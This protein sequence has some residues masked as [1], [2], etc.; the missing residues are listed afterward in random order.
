[1][2][3]TDKAGLPFFQIHMFGGFNIT[4]ADVQ[5]ADETMRTKK[6]WM[7]I[8]YLIANKDADASIDKIISDIWGDE[9]SDDPLNV[10]KNLVYRSRNI[11]KKLDGNTEFI[12]YSQNTYRWNPAVHCEVDSDIFKRSLDLAEKTKIDEEKIEHYFKAFQLYRGDFLPHSSYADW[13]INK[14]TYYASL[15]LTAVERICKILMD[16]ERYESVIEVCE[17]ASTHF[18][19]EEKIHE[20]LL[21]AYISTGRYSRAI[22]H[23]NYITELFYKELGVCLSDEIKGLYKKIINS[24]SSVE[25]DLSTICEDLQETSDIKGAFFC[26]YEV[27]KNIYRIQARSIARTGQSINIA[28]MTLMGKNKEI[29][30]E[31]V[32]KKSVNDLKITILNDLRK[33]DV[34]S[35]FSSV[36]FV[37][38]LPVTTCEMANMVCQRIITRFNRLHKQRDVRV[39]VNIRPLKPIDL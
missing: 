16:L 4:C 13:V 33:G 5:V 31:K 8:Q 10:L 22:K 11:L 32:L 24:I 34:V 9:E 38:M 39:E 1:M 17:T 25:M 20:F 2:K 35:A 14:S 3:Q 29:P 6:A 37:M 23:Y 12:L 26:D 27:F 30:D 19:L 15:Y 28:L 7:L 18:L 21:N 36:Q